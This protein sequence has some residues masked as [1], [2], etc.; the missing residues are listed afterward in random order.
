MPALLF[1]TPGNP[2]FF[3]FHVPPIPALAGHVLTMQGASLEVGVCFRATDAVVA[4]VQ[5]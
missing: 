4:W 3:C 5:P 1:S 2:A